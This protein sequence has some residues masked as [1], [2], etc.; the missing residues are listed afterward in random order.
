MRDCSLYLLNELRTK[1]N[2][3]EIGLY[4]DD[5]LGIMR[6]QSGPQTERT[7]KKIPEIFKSLSSAAFNKWTF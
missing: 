2:D 6:N 3:L 7:K 1:C 5:G 4:R